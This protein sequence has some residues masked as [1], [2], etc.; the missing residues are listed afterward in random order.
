VLWLPSHFRNGD[1][2][3]QIGALARARET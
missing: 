2:E 1:V 3:A